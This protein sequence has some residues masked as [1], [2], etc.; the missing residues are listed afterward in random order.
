M[1]HGPKQV[2]EQQENLLT[3][4]FLVAGYC[5][6]LMVPLMAYGCGPEWARWDAAQAVIAYEQ[7]DVEGAILQL[8]AAV[9]K[10]PRDPSLKLSL[11]EKL[12]ESN[13]P[14]QAER[15][16]D[17]ILK[18]F[19]DSDSALVRKAN[20]QQAQGNFKKALETF[21][22]RAKPRSWLISDSYYKLNERAY[23][24][25][26]A[27]LELDHARDDIDSAMSMVAKTPLGGLEHSVSVLSRSLVTA[28]LIGRRVAMTDV[29]I[30]RLTP[31]ID[32]LRIATHAAKILL[33]Q[34]II[35]Q[36][37]EQFPPTAEVIKSNNDLRAMIRGLEKTSA[38][39]LT[40]RALCF[41]DLD[42]ID[43]SNQDRAEVR[44]MALDADSIVSELPTENECIGQLLVSYMLLDTRG[45][46]VS[47]GSQYN[48]PEAK[49]TEVGSKKYEISQSLNDALVDLNQAIF[50]LDVFAKSLDSEVHNH[51]ESQIDPKTMK[52]GVPKMKAVLFYHRMLL[53]E[54]MGNQMAA[55]LDK[56]T[57]GRL[58]YTP[59]WHLF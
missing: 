38:L 14:F 40:T 10:S 17:E 54:K 15:V 49:A 51:M 7:G 39:L 34:Q 20:S 37:S 44:S 29:A 3:R 45:Y 50:A 47:L 13:Q 21:K 12:I 22:K 48:E 59:G 24:R 11:A 52:L 25:A 19:P 35:E 30:D 41:Q 1:A 26:L 53:L 58:G 43:L 28:A 46:I 27:N 2:I 9:K 8:K 55:D 57:I 32:R 16:C 23:Y 18:R 4:S 36:S 42:M 31:M 33:N 56:E 6:V 5:A